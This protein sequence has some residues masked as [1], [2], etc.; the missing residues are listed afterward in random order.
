MDFAGGSIGE[1]DVIGIL[2][3]IEML[4]GDVV[5]GR[6]AS[7]G[8]FHARDVIFA[9]VAGDGHPAG[10]AAL[11]ANHSD[12]HGGIR[13]AGNRIRNIKNRGI[14][15][16]SGIGEAGYDFFRRAE[17]VE[18]FE[19]SDVAGVELPV[20]DAATVGT[21]A[22]GVAEVEFFFVHPVGGAVDD[23]GRAV[24]GDLGGGSGGDIFD[25]D[26]I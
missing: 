3:A 12:A 21:P 18:E 10:F 26:I 5:R 6:V 4:D 11:R 16:E 1:E 7:R 13:S 19:N 23:G 9:R 25:V 15:A 8:P 24:A 17:I 2:Q 22:K 14:H 20:G